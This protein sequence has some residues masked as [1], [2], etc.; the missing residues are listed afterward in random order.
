LEIL[1]YRPKVALYFSAEAIMLFADIASLPHYKDNLD[2]VNVSRN[3]SKIT[4]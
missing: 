4:E 3:I 2:L 1:L